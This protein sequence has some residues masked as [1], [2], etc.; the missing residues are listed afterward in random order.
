MNTMEALGAGP[1]LSPKG[2]TPGLNLGADA[3][4]LALFAS[5]FAMMQNPQPDGAETAASSLVTQSKPDVTDSTPLLPAAAMLM[6]S[7]APSVEVANPDMAVSGD[8]AGDAAS[9]DMVPGDAAGLLKLLLAAHDIAAP[10][11]QPAAP[12]PAPAP[13]ADSDA[14]IVP[15]AP[16]RTA[17][18][19]LTGAIEILK[20]LGA[21]PAEDVPAVADDA[22]PKEPAPMVMVPPSNDFIGPMPAV[23]PSGALPAP[24]VK[25]Q[26]GQDFI[27]PMPIVTHSAAIVP[28][29]DTASEFADDANPVVTAP[30]TLGFIGPM[31]AMT[32]AAT[33]MPAAVTTAVTTVIAAPSPDFVGPMP[34]VRSVAAVSNGVPNSVTP[35][36]NAAPETGRP[37]R[38][39]Q[40]VKHELPKAMMDQAGDTGDD[41]SVH[42]RADIQAAVKG[43]TERAASQNKPAEIQYK[44]AEMQ[45]LRQ[46]M[47]QARSDAGQNAAPSNS[48]AMQG[49]VQQLAS[50]SNGG[51]PLSAVNGQ[52]SGQNLAANA[53]ASTA[54]GQSGNHAGGHSG[55]Q[56]GGQQAAQQMVDGGPARGAADRTILHR[57]NTDNAGWSET[58]VKRLTADLRSG[59][60]NVR[61]ILEPRQLG[62]LNVELGLR[63]GKASIRIATE[64]QEAARLLSGARAQL[65]QMLES[66]GMRL[67]SFQATGSHGGDTSL[68]TGQGS[69][70]RG[71]EGAGDNTGRNN[72]GRNQDFSNKM[73]TTLEDHNDDQAAGDNALRE[74]ETAVLSILA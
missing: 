32:Q 61:I 23:M 66:A 22:L 58:M 21:A 62:R 50:S 6:A 59:V 44:P 12:T 2:E 3:E 70:N 31:P 47:T 9:G 54:G 26:A 14:S 48:A 30:P 11:H 39:D 57:L 56:S 35:S 46:Q 65:G 42:R 51:N 45:G 43:M 74:G 71:G 40:L 18:E 69:Q 41:G 19:M 20:S 34:A 7:L 29:S 16:T 60:Q 10:D 68:D 1:A 24:A 13:A 17:T 67:A 55:N 27:G 4:T 53:T 73:S 33:A 15:A 5:L 28:S 38:V 49:L 63:N 64:T 25:L 52:D 37:G 72:T 8:V 36:L